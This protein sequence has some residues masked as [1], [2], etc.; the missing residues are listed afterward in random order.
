[1]Q[2]RFSAYVEASRAVF[3]IIDEMSPIVERV[4]IDEAFLD[5][6]GLQRVAGSPV[7]I[8][9]RLRRTVREQV[10]LTL[11]VGIATTKLLAKVVSG[12]AKPD[13]LLLVPPERELAFLHPL[14]VRRLW[15]VGAVTAGN[16]QARHRDRRRPRASR[17]AGADRAAR[18]RDGTLP[19]RRGVQPRRQ[20]A[21][22]E[23][24]AG[25]L[26]LAARPR[27]LADHGRPA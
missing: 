25:L 2:P 3:E 8:A 23:S 24:P 15:G 20:A 19:A 7:Q 18:A 16:L 27:A 26:R 4:S 21:A 10:G 5:V 6:R 12:V 14:A 1:V 17:R 22:H 9:T 11:T 13:G